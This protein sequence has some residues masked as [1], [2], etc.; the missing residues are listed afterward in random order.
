MDRVY[1]VA[2]GLTGT[3]TVEYIRT[4]NMDEAKKIFDEKHP[5]GMKSYV[6]QV[7]DYPVY[8]VYFYYNHYKPV[9]FTGCNSKEDV[10]EYI[11]RWGLS[12]NR[13]VEKIE[14]V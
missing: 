2:N 8:A 12:T 11:N 4:A 7:V 5:F 6:F 9:Y 14:L 10:E 3:Y 13:E 1:R